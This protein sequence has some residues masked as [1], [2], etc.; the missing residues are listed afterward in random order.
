MRLHLRDQLPRSSAAPRQRRA[1]PPAAGPAA[2][3]SRARDRA[4]PRRAAAAPA[5]RARR[6]PARQAAP[7]RQRRCGDCRPRR[8]AGAKPRP[9]RPPLRVRRS[10]R[11]PGRV[12]SR[13]AGR[14][15]PH[16]AAGRRGRAAERP[17]HGENRR[18][19]HQRQQEPERHGGGFTSGAKLPATAIS[20]HVWRALCARVRS[21]RAP[22]T[23]WAYSSPNTLAQNC[24]AA[25]TCDCR[26]AR[27]LSPEPRSASSSV[28]VP[29]SRHCCSSVNVRRVISLIASSLG[30]VAA[31]HQRS[32]PAIPPAPPLPH[33]PSPWG[34][35]LAL[36]AA[37]GVCTRAGV[38]R[39]PSIGKVL[40]QPAILHN[41]SARLLLLPARRRCG[42]VLYRWHGARRTAGHASMTRSHR[43]VHQ[44]ASARARIVS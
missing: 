34:R 8:A 6:A 5:R 44:R 17:Q 14:D 25:S 35:L 39:L 21:D 12:R 18:R 16:I 13:R 38:C 33:R 36:Y 10:G 22:L 40:E 4:R 32:Q 2:A 3:A 20:R 41:S 31:C 19:R 28:L 26:N 15:R 27:S 24:T 7:P 37:I 42:L 43:T 9:A 11:P 30:V 1:A 23:S 29:I